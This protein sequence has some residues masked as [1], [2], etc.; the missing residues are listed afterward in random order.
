ML[1]HVT[2]R[3][4][5]EKRREDISVNTMFQRENYKKSLEKLKAIYNNLKLT[6]HCY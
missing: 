2:E 3:K 6:S 5:I 1:M 4:K